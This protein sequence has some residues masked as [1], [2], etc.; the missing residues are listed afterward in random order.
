MVPHYMCVICTLYFTEED[1][2]PTTGMLPYHEFGHNKIFSAFSRLS[3]ALKNC[4]ELE[5]LN[6][7]EHSPGAYAWLKCADGVNCVDKMKQQAGIEGLPGTEFGATTSC[8][9][10]AIYH[11]VN[12]YFLIK[13]NL[14]LHVLA[15]QYIVWRPITNVSL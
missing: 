8:K 4:K 13:F 12:K 14:A 3:E 9:S 2:S 5:V 6:D 10:M 11:A 15:P 1:P 7:I